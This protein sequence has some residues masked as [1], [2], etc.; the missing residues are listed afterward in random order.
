MTFQIEP[1]G[2]THADGV[3]DLI[4]PIQRDEFGLDITYADQPDL[5]DIPGFYRQG[6]GEFW[7]ACT[8]DGSV[9]GSV[10]LIDIGAHQTALRKMFVAKAYRGEPH[11]LARALLET[12][13]A[14]A[15]ASGV[16]DI[17]LGTTDAFRAAHRFYEKAGF[18]LIDESDLP[19]AFPRMAVDTRFYR[20][21]LD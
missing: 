8:D 5:H 13:V 2:A 7:V 1:F 3:R 10:A 6:C 4:V 18:D 15:H 11:G 17:F 9:V 20:Q 16:A 14:H 19:R 12:L 21:V